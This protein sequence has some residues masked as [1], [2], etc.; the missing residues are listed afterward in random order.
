MP[1]ILKAVTF[2]LFINYQMYELCLALV[3]KGN[4]KEILPRFEVQGARHKVQV[5]AFRIA[6]EAIVS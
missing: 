1:A 4:A 5:A 6:V 2:S 3:F